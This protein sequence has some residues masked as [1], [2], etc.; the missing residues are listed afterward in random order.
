MVDCIGKNTSV[1]NGIYPTGN[2]QENVEK[3]TTKTKRTPHPYLKR[4]YH[5][6][7]VRML[8]EKPYHSGENDSSVKEDSVKTKNGQN[9]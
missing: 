4:Y 5:V 8:W 3:T 2:V 7:T 6:L 9:E 1:N